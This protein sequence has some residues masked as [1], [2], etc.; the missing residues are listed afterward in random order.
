MGQLCWEN[1]RDLQ[2]PELC[3]GNCQ[4]SWSSIK[5]L[6][7]KRLPRGFVLLSSFPKPE[8]QAQLALT[9][10]RLTKKNPQGLMRTSYSTD[11]CSNVPFEQSPSGMNH[12][13]EKGGSAHLT[14]FKYSVIQDNKQV[15]GQTSSVPGEFTGPWPA[16][17]YC[18]LF[19][20]AL[21]SASSFCKRNPATSSFLWA[22]QDSRGVCFAYQQ[23]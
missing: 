14:Y 6:L 4:W 3:L 5:F 21:N 17:S 11:Q 19:L 2:L 13:R 10:F 20:K 23:A 18:N 1:G 15:W 22:L 12:S 7:L 16:E 8:K 9:I